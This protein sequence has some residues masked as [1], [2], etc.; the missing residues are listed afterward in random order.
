M[1]N[2]QARSLADLTKG[3]AAIGLMVEQSSAESWGG[4]IRGQV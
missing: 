4:K 2:K 3:D 1:E